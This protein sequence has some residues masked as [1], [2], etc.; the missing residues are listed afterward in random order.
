MKTYLVLYRWCCRGSMLAQS[1]QVR[2]TS[3]ADAQG[4]VLAGR[5]GAQIVECRKLAADK[6]LEQA[7]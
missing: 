4:Q 7:A 5:P 2:A 6:A 3:I 1:T